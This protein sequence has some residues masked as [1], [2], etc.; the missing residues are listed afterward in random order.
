M[1]NNVV[2]GRTPLHSAAFTNDTEAVRILLRYGADATAV[3]NQ[4]RLLVL[5]AWCL[6]RDWGQGS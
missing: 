1:V 3:Y 6:L 4:V 5:F 2:Q